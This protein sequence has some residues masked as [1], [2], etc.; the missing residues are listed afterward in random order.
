[1]YGALRIENTQNDIDLHV[2]C[3]L[4]LSFSVTAFKIK[5]TWTRIDCHPH[6]HFIKKKMFSL[7]SVYS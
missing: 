4:C 1:M 3:F 2:W 7:E 6:A 5:L